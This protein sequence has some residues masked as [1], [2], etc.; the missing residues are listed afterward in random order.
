M[1]IKTT[2]PTGSA[3]ALAPLA[4]WLR[5]LRRRAEAVPYDLIAVG[6]RIFPA[7]VFWQSGLTKLDEH[8]RVSDNAV[9]LFQEEYRLP[10]L[11]PGWPPTRRPQRS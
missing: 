8:W 6:A 2:F 3:P 4:I 1:T 11:D 9:F 7:A 5:G 10:L